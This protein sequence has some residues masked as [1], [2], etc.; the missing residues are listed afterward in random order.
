MDE[1][2]DTAM[3]FWR[4]I[5]K[6]RMTADGVVSESPAFIFSVIIASD[7][8]G[9]ADADLYDGHSASGEKVLDLYCA[10]EVMAGLRF[11]PP[12]FFNRGIYVDIGTNCES[13]VVQYLPLQA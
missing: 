11:N 9:E 5:A 2:H 6:R 12:M 13:V 4:K 1:W 8:G 10:D 7:G 3:K